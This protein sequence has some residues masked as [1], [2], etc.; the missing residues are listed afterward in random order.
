MNYKRL[1]KVFN[2]SKEQIKLAR[3]VL[4]ERIDPSE[5]EDLFPQTCE[6][7]GQCYNRPRAN[8][9]QIEALNELLDGYGVEAIEHEEIYVDRYHGNIVASY[10][11]VGETYAP[12]LILDHIKNRWLVCS[13]GDFYESLDP[14]KFQD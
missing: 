5:R 8:E 14:S 3:D 11:N 10:V 13:W 7:I 1:A 12:T 4:N 6:W 9:I 2:L